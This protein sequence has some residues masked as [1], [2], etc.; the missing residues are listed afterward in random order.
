MLLFSPKMLHFAFSPSF[1]SAPQV[2]SLNSVLLSPVFSIW[3]HGSPA[4]FLISSLLWL[5]C[6]LPS[7]LNP[8]VPCPTLSSPLMEASLLLAHWLLSSM[9]SR[10][11]VKSDPEPMS[12][13]CVGQGEIGTTGFSPRRAGLSSAQGCSGAKD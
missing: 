3:P 6:S 10:V 9:E 5:S 7:S 8:S 11:T 12:K 2:Q 4:A 13:W 1:S